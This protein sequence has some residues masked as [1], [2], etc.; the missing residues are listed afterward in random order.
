MNLN[1][2]REALNSDWESAVEEKQTR[3]Q[4][5]EEYRRLEGSMTELTPNEERRYRELAKMLRMCVC[6]ECGKTYDNAKSRAM[7]T[8]FCSGK[9]MNVVA[10]R[11]GY[12]KR[13]KSI[14]NCLRAAGKIGHDFLYK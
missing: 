9:C 2:R 14:F 13:E 3:E 6:R 7:Y 4:M 11:H 8:G 5:Y 10:K 1:R 12:P